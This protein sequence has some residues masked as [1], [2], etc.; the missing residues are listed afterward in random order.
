MFKHIGLVAKQG[1]DR[2][3]DTLTGLI[4]YLEERGQQYSVHDG[5]T[6]ALPGD[7]IDCGNLDALG[8]ECDLALVVGG[9]GTLLSAAR[10]LVDYEVP[11]LGINRGRLGFLTDISPQSLASR[12]D[13][14]LAGEYQVE[15]RFLLHAVIL[16]DG[17][18]VLHGDALNDVV[19]HKWKIARLVEFATY[20][21]GIYVNTQR[22]DGI[23]I[24][25]P[26]GSTAYALSGGGP[27]LHPALNAVVLVSICP[28]TL[29][30]RPIVVDAN[31]RIEVLLSERQQT[32]AQLTNDGQTAM[33]L[34]TGD[35]IVITKKPK[36]LRLVHPV[37][38]D[39]YAMLRTKLHWS[40]EL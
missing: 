35:R 16:R 7:S 38:Y 39:Y 8:R 40:K 33:E 37:G 1:D 30:Q 11:V 3:T 21:D 23:I 25:T 9:D 14:I 6:A 22:S 4:T 17:H 34:E 28:H 5:C 18:E 32:S 29:S 26:T 13:R 20:V 27:I 2:V 24:S 15:K 12:L 31:S 19:M 36:P 10:G